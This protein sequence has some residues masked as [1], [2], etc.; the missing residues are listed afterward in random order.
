MALE[1]GRRDISKR[2]LAALT[3]TAEDGTNQV[4]CCYSRWKLPLLNTCSY[5]VSPSYISFE[6]ILLLQSLEAPV[7]QYLQLRRESTGSL[8]RRH[9]GPQPSS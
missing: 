1:K 3:H 4:S 2:Q 9:L 6:S 5:V 7:T 8:H